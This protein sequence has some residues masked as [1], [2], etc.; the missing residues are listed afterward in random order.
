MQDIDFDEDIEENALYLVEATFVD[1]DIDRRATAFFVGK[2]F[3][4]LTELA[5]TPADKDDSGLQLT[6]PRISTSTALSGQG[7]SAITLWKQDAAS[8]WLSVSAD[9]TDVIISKV[10]L[11]NGSGGGAGGATGQASPGISTES[12]QFVKKYQRSSTTPADPADVYNEVDTDFETD[13]GDWESDVPTGTDTLWVADGGWKYSDTGNVE[14]VGWRVYASLTAQYASI[15]QDNSTYTDTSEVDSRYVRFLTPDGWSSW[16]P[17]EDGVRGWIDI[18][19]DQEIGVTSTA[20]RNNL[21]VTGGFDSEWFRE[22]QVEIEVYGL[23]TDGTEN[24]GYR[25]IGEARRTT[26]LWTEK[27]ATTNTGLDLGA[28]KIRCTDVEGM[29]IVR[30]IGSD[31][32]DITTNGTSPA[33]TSGAYRRFSFQLSLINPNPLNSQLF[34][35]TCHTWNRVDVNARI[36][37]RMR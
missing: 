10:N 21:P 15:V 27:T 5:T 3:L 8:G 7:V 25:I 1:T 13:F 2:T 34:W 37:V 30:A 22:I 20:N 11:D 19:T 24:P 33:T 35:I 9:T 29:D 28:F 16:S 17:I 14:N 31:I 18:I 23:Q 36:T 6:I 12:G 32:S 4:D 26:G